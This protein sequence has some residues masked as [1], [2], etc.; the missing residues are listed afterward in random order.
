[1][2][3]SYTI[4]GIWSRVKVDEAILYFVNVGEAVTIELIEESIQETKHK[5]MEAVPWLVGSQNLGEYTS[6][7]TESCGWCSCKAYCEGLG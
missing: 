1:M 2:T 6:C 7:K 5:L 4:P 3:L